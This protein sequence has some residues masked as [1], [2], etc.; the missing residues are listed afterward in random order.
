MEAKSVHKSSDF[1]PFRNY[2]IVFKDF[3]VE[4]KI[5]EFKMFMNYIN[6]IKKIE[7]DAKLLEVGTGNGWFQILCHMNGIN[8]TGL[9]ILPHNIE[10]AKKLAKENGYDINILL[11]SIETTDIGTSKYDIIIAFSVFEHVKYW[12]TG[13]LNVYNALKP[14]G[15]LLFISTNKFSLVSGECKFPFYGWLPKKMRYRF[16]MWLHG[17][18]VMLYNIDWNQFTFFHLK[19]FFKFMGFSKIF[20]IWDIVELDDF[21]DSNFLKKLLIRFLTHSKLLKKLSLWILPTTLFIC[22]K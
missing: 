21:K 2:E 20:N 5:S 4:N 19:R 6:R 12:Q 8:S 11:G 22:I 13:L 16:R 1:K 14:G 7:R 17:K 15:V 3:K 18:D 10:F 9:D